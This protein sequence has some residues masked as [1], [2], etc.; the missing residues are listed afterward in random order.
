VK[1]LALAAWLVCVCAAAAQ[2]PRISDINIYGLHKLSPERVLSAAKLSSGDRL[3]AS[4]GDLEDTLEKI[5]G[6]VMARVEGVC[7]DGA[8]VVLFI[9]IEERGA[10]RPSFRSP[11][12][13]SAIL[14]QELVDTYG[15]FLAAV[16][17]AAAEG[18][19]TEDLTAGHS[20]MDVADAS[21]F[22]PRFSDFD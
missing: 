20:R 11:P 4:K 22:Q 13:G 18:R 15:R 19:A 2:T 7:C 16:A 3:P 9:G 17:R 10:P 21:D 14:P 1:P 12:A 6:V 5:S 8:D